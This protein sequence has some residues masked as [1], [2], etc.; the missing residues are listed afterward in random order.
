M[1]RPLGTR[2][3]VQNDSD[4]AIKVTNLHKSFNLPT[5]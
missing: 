1:K 5:E 4:I 3:E 2:T